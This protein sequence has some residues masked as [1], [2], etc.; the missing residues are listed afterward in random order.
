M[1]PEVTEILKTI[2]ELSRRLREPID[3]EML[4]GG[5]SEQSAVALSEGLVK[6]AAKI[7]LVDHMP[8]KSERPWNM[9]RIL[10]FNSVHGGGLFDDL[11]ALGLKLRDMP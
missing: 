11:L 3:D 6:F 5:W 7:K 2:E 4:T 10:D 8:P 1:S 9:I